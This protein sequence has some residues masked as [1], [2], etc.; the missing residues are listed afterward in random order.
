MGDTGVQAI[1]T[2]PLCRMAL[3]CLVALPLQTG[4]PATPPSSTPPPPPYP[5]SPSIDTATLEQV[6]PKDAD[7]KPILLEVGGVNLTLGAP[8]KDAIGAAAKCTDL[9]SNCVAATKDMD[10]CVADLPRCAGAEPWNEDAP[11]CADACVRAYQEERRL[12]ATAFEADAA[13]F[14]STHE[15]FPGL[16]DLYRSYGGT[17]RRFPRRAP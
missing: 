11:C 1:M 7:G 5:Q 14:S 16:V 6:L 9:Y 12:G 4:C 15:C 8:R 3:L 2:N 13:V 17:P 10:R